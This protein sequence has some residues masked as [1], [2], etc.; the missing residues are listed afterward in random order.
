MLHT[1]ES[2]TVWKWILRTDFPGSCGLK[3]ATVCITAGL[4]GLIP[5]CF[6]RFSLNNV[7][8]LTL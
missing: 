2:D 3:N 6:N 7:K 5:L 4:N 8:S 1:E